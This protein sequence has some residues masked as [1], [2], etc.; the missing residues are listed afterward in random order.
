LAV[1]KQQTF[2]KRDHQRDQ[3]NGR[4][5][6]TST[7]DRRAAIARTDAQTFFLH[8]QDLDILQQDTGRRAAGWCKNRMKN[9]DTTLGSEQVVM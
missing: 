1:V 9:V 7:R 3:M 5:A 4:S 8:M 2:L 6:G